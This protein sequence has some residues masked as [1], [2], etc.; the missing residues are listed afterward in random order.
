MGQRH[1]VQLYAHADE[2]VASIAAYIADGF[3]A[4]A[5]AAVILTPETRARVSRR[6]RETGV[7]VDAL[8]ASG[9]LTFA[10]ADATLSSF[11]V[12]G[13]PSAERFEHVVGGL[14]DEIADRHPEQRIRA[15]GEMVELLVDRGQPDAA[16]SLEE[17]WNSLAWSRDF[18][19]FCG[20]SSSRFDGGAQADVL[21]E[22]VRTHSH[23]VPA[24]AAA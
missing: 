15:V 17:L 18:W 1:S 16:I 22:I 11:V 6:L 10:D 2:F 7:D 3:A 9:L 8:E 13:L 12:D 14:L 20:Y 24:A 23:V 5:P 19:L 4:G 21:A